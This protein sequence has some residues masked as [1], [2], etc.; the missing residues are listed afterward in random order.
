MNFANVEI[1][2]VAWLLATY[3]QQRHPA[4]IAWL[5]YSASRY[6][7]DALRLACTS[8]GGHSGPDSA[9]LHGGRAKH[10]M[11]RGKLHVMAEDALLTTA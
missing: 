5:S 1:I 9:G 11:T 10:G 6:L 4:L 7:H 8:E 2:A 3:A